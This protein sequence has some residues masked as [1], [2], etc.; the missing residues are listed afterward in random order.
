MM[1]KQNKIYLGIGI[2]AIILIVAVVM[3]SAPKG[4]ETIKIG[5][6]GP[7]TG[8]VA[9]IG[10]GQQKALMLAQEEINSQGGIDGK[11]VNII[12]EDSKCD[13]KSAVDAVNKL[14]N[15][16]GVQYI[17]GGQCSSETLGAAPVVEQN[18]VIMISPLSSN[19][20]ITNSGDYIFRVYPSDSFQGKYA[21]NYIKNNLNKN[22]VAVMSCLDDWCKGF[23]DVF[24]QEFRDLGGNIV[25]VQEFEKRSSDL[26]TQLTK[27]K[28]KNPEL[29]FM[30][31]YTDSAV[32]A[33]RQAQELD[34]NVN[35]FGGDAWDES[36]LWERSSEYNEGN[37]YVMPKSHESEEFV[38]KFRSKYGSEE[39][40]VLG[41]MHNY[42]ALKIIQ[43]AIESA[44]DDTAEVKNYLYSMSPYSGYS[45]TISFDENGDLVGAEYGVKESVNDERVV[46]N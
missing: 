16:D 24:V 26:K 29:I 12:F 7:L 4:E 44:G 40:I 17:V 18:K 28:Q 22:T 30:A 6:I 14:I 23:K 31:S 2:V 41:A 9:S 19:P 43:K 13:G 3:F 39:E 8:D 36:T 21:A 34:L 11:K 45:G 25:E 20:D 35:F 1:K 38:T 10:L 42:D 15:I 32:T 5:H 27:I 46:I 33:F 37:M